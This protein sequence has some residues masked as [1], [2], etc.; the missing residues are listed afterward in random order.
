MA[1]GVNNSGGYRPDDP[2][3]GL[4]GQALQDYYLSRPTQFFI[5]ALY[6]PKSRDLRRQAMAAHQAHVRAHR[7]QIQF[8]GPFVSDDGATL[9]GTMCVIDVPDRAAAE[10]YIAADGYNQAGLL[11]QPEIRRFVSS[12]TLR[13]GDRAPEIGMQ[14]FVCECIDGPDATE[15][16]KQTA[17]AHHTYQGSIIDRFVAHGP[18]RSDDGLQVQGSLFIIE[19][20]DRTAAEALVSAEPMTAGGVFEKVRITR[21]RYGT[22]LA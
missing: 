6:K 8:A 16:R 7:A 14:M 19:V 4:S 18:L 10:A 5:R 11:E 17:A 1:D 9:I 20:V 22:S 21:W 12:K 3:Y 13:Q 15:R 2:R